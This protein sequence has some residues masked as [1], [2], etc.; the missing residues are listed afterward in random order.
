MRL[1]NAR[2]P[3]NSRNSEAKAERG[4]RGGSVS[5]EERKLTEEQK[6]GRRTCALEAV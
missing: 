4:G 6:D 3:Y 1:K 2:G 5:V